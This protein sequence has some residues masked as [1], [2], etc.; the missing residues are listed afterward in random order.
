MTD[1]IFALFLI[2]GCFYLVKFFR[3]DRNHLLLYSSI[4]F[5][6]ATFIRPPGFIFFLLEILLVIGFFFY[7]TVNQRR[8]KINLN[9]S[10]SNQSHLLKLNKKKFFKIG[11]FFILPWLIFILFWLSFNVFY[12]GDPL[13]SYADISPKSSTNAI[14]TP[15]TF[16]QLD[17]KF[18]EYT[19]YYSVP[20]LP[21]VIK[22]LL[23]IISGNEKGDDFTNNWISIFP[24][25]IFVSALAVSLYYKTK[26]TE[27]II[28][29]LFTTGWI[30][31]YSSNFI[32][33]PIENHPTSF[34]R[35]RYMIPMMPFSFILFGFIIHKIWEINLKKVLMNRYKFISVSFKISFVILVFILLSVSL[36][37]SKP[38]E[39]I[40]NNTYTIEN[41][42]AFAEKYPPDREGLPENSVIVGDASRKAIAYN[43]TIFFPYWGMGRYSETTPDTIPK[44][45]I[46]TLKKIMEQGYETYMFKGGASD[47][48]VLYFRYLEAEHGIVLKD[49]SKTFCKLELV[50]KNNMSETESQSDE[51]CYSTVTQS[52]ILTR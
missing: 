26:R 13:T 18:I 34:L 5:T 17:S 46:I 36:L 48:D 1:N 40:F 39:D 38:V 52:R 35:Y 21:D 15:S 25:L 8:K 43:A 3:E 31:F 37:S 14:K 2:L 16:F 20:L 12:F 7:Q 28:F 6:I 11:I 24:I 47:R 19:K 4:F 44:E 22:E 49:F 50:E 10:L 45:P 29:I 27:V 9:S 30:S 32:A 42:Q 41:P 51:L 33:S 23:V